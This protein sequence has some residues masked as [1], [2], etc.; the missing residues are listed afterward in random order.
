MQQMEILCGTF[1]A[2]ETRKIRGLSRIVQMEY[3]Q[4]HLLA[5]DQKETESSD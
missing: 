1:K 4:S 3:I 2:W 5:W